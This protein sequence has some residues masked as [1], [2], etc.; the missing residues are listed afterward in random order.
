MYQVARR[1]IGRKP[2][3][4][5]WLAQQFGRRGLTE[6]ERRLLGGEEMRRR[7]YDALERYRDGRPMDGRWPES[8]SRRVR[9]QCGP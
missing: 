7:A 5:T 1:I 9:S 6:H 2:V 3:S 4:A 8:T